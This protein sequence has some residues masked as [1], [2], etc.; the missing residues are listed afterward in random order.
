[1]YVGQIVRETYVLLAI[2]LHN[3]SVIT[4]RILLHETTI[5]VL[6]LCMVR[7]AVGVWAVRSLISLAHLLWWSLKA[8]THSQSSLIAEVQLS[9]LPFPSAKATGR[10]W[11]L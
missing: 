2:K 9:L 8:A 11:Q 4:H 10:Y 6:T 5:L 3:S 7:E 1:M